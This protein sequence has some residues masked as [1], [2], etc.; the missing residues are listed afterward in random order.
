MD[1]HKTEEE[2]ADRYFNAARISWRHVSVLFLT[3]LLFLGFVLLVVFGFI[4]DPKLLRYGETLSL[5]AFAGMFL[6][7]ILRWLDI[8]LIFSER[9]KIAKEAGGRLLEFHR[10]KYR[11]K[12]QS[13][14]SPELLGKLLGFLVPV[15]VRVRCFDPF[16]EDLKADRLEKLARSGSRGVKCWIEFTFYWRL[17]VTVVNS[18]VCYLGDTLLKVALFFKGGS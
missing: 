12:A 10:E 16:F 1:T 8:R 15:T 5:A 17:C 4:N 14:P 11:H 18:L 2:I 6:A 13:I 3:S 7:L 9:D